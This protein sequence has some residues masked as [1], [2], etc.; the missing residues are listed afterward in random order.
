MPSEFIS[1]LPLPSAGEIRPDVRGLVPDARLQGPGDRREGIRGPKAD[2]RPCALSEAVFQRE[3][4]R[5]AAQS[6]H[7]STTVGEFALLLI[8]QKSQAL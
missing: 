7:G 1:L 8:T 2:L 6:E 5:D 4:C 3:L